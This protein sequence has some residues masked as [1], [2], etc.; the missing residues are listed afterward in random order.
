VVWNLFESL[1][2][3]LFKAQLFCEVR[4]DDPFGKKTDGKLTAWK[5]IIEEE[6]GEREREKMDA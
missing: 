5:W 2:R 3:N 4:I 6:G 1:K